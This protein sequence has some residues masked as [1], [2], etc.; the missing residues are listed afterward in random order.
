MKFNR[1]LLFCV[2]SMLM[3]GCSEDNTN[4]TSDCHG[5]SRPSANCT[6]QNNQWSC[7]DDENKCPDDC[8]DD[9]DENGICKPEDQI[10]CPD[11]CLDDC[12][13]NGN[14]ASKCPDECLDDCTD[15][16]CNTPIHIECP[17][18]CPNDCDAE[19]LCRIQCPT[20]CPNDC[21]DE[22]KC[23]I[24]CP[25]ECPTDCIDATT[26]PVK[27]SASCTNSCNPDGSCPCP[28]TCQTTCDDDGV[29]QCPK[30]CATTCNA[31]GECPAMCGSEIVKKM[32]FSFPENDLL[33]PGYGARQAVTIPIKIQTNKATYT[34]TD[35]PCEI[36]L[37]SS[38][39]KIMKVAMKDN[40]PT[41]SPVAAGRATGT[42]TIKG[43]NMSATVKINV[44]N[45][46]NLTENVAKKNS[47]GNLI[48]VYKGPFKLNRSGRVCQ[49][50]DVNTQTAFKDTDYVYFSQLS[51]YPLSEE[52][53]PFRTRI[54]VFPDRLSDL[55]VAKKAMSLFHSGHGQ[56]LSIEHTDTQDYVWVGSAGSLESAT[57]QSKI[58]K[59]FSSSQTLVRV[60]FEADKSYYPEDLEHYYLPP[61]DGSSYYMGL[62]PA[63][64]IKNNRFLLRAKKKGDSKTYIKI[65]NFKTF[66]DLPT[67]SKKVT[68]ANPVT[69]IKDG[70]VVANQKL[71]LKV[72]DL[73]EKSIKPIHQFAVTNFPS[74][75]VTIDNGIIYAVTNNSSPELSKPDG[76]YTHHFSITVKLYSQAGK[77]LASHT[78][79]NSKLNDGYLI[80]KEMDP[81]INQYDENGNLVYWNV[82]YFEPEGIRV[83]DGKLYLNISAKRGY[84][85]DNG[86][87]AI[88]A[89]Q[90]IF[91]YDLA[92]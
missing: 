55:K 60:P 69:T 2:S 62:E 92:K 64:D 45:P 5:S 3:F 66:R 25:N 4:I 53:K 15:G 74:Q 14:C 70:K 71:T 28:E 84:K 7:P 88:T 49:G 1:S 44:L 42:A 56:G 58:N 34:N 26:C 83:R 33:I 8:L 54:V 63:L 22:G 17:E 19:G 43:Q 23:E 65:Y 38:N 72:K 31:N 85:D 67:A 36:E 76:K 82:G 13:I 57:D 20:E 16:I 39:E 75:G 61:E 52:G 50:F 41:F 89:A 80:N 12:D 37:K 21:D 10:I 59:G 90:Y 81:I 9:C 11:D 6:C 24:V 73:S 29:C 87:D 91:V 47:K 77:E 78:I 48:H 18:A 30:E 68:L 32:Y 40:V 35:A 27:C 86:K 51:E 46:Q 79:Q